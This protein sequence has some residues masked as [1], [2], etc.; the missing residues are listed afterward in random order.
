MTDLTRSL[1][2]SGTPWE[3]V[4][5]YELA[6]INPGWT[7]VALGSSWSYLLRRTGF[8]SAKRSRRVAYF[9]GV[10]RDTCSTSRA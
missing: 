8:T 2:G 10:P 5:F 7:P 4:G 3:C 1:P 6:D 9:S